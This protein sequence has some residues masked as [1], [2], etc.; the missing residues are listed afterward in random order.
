MRWRMNE[1]KLDAITNLLI[2][3]LIGKEK[4]RHQEC[5]IRVPIDQMKTDSIQLHWILQIRSEISA[6]YR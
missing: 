3:K 1:K 6:K 2:G 4:H 5:C